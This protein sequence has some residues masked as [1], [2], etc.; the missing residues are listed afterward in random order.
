MVV[1]SVEIRSNE[2][3]TMSTMA[4]DRGIESPGR[5]VTITNPYTEIT[6]S[7]ALELKMQGK[8]EEAL[9]VYDSVLE[10]NP[11]ESRA[12]HAKGDIHDMMGHLQDAV[13]CYD[14]ALECDP[15]NAETWYSKGV[16]LSKMGCGDDSAECMLQ[17][18]SLA[19]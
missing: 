9:R 8:Y 15:F 12:H 11:R 14:S 6:L 10:M 5:I 7:Q 1:V 19:I 18:M 3:K 2:V 17:S 16:T 13:A 4:A